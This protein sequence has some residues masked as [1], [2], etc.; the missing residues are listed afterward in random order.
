[1]LYEL[2]ELE[3]FRQYVADNALECLAHRPERLQDI[4]D[5]WRDYYREP[6]R[7][8]VLDEIE[9]MA[10]GFAGETCNRL[11][12]QPV[13]RPA[14]TSVRSEVRRKRKPNLDKLIAKAKAAGART[15]VVE[16]VEMRFGEPVSG[17]GAATDV[18]RELEEFE[19]R[20]G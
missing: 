1:M 19:A 9:A 15:V 14:E 12:V 20:H 7:L 6:G 18:D 10:R 17:N 13:E 11:Q 8:A 2:D 4:F 3:M 16:G 5:H